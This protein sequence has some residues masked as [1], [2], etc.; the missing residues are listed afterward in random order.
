MMRNIIPIKFSSDKLQPGLAFLV[1]SYDYDLLRHGI[2]SW[3][4]NIIQTK[5]PEK[6]YTPDTNIG[7]CVILGQGHDMYI[8]SPK[9]CSTL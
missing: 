5:S 2:V 3:T 1:V 9:F 4:W 8:I 7:L 6:S